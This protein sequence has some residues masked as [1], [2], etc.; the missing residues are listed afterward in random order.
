MYRVVIEISEQHDCQ[1]GNSG[2]NGLTPS[3]VN[4]NRI[5]SV[6]FQI[7]DASAGAWRNIDAD[8]GAADT[9]YDGSEINH[10]FNPA[11]GVLRKESGDY[12]GAT[13]SGGFLA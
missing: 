13:S 4:G 6:A 10:T 1:N 12:G 2:V 8:A 5:M 9:L 3:K 7:R 11:T